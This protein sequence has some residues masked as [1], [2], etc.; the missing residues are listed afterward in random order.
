MI[1]EPVRHYLASHGV[2]FH[3]V[4]HEPRFSAQEAAEAA[5]VSGKHFAKAV[6]LRGTRHNAVRHYLLAVLP[7][8]EKV[9]IDRLSRVLGERYEL[10][11]E[12][13]TATLFPGIEV[14]ALPPL[15]EL[16]GVPVVAD[17]AMRNA[18]WIVF[19]GGRLTDLVE[20][21]WDDYVRVAAPRIIDYARLPF[22]IHS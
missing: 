16:G 20:V 4:S 7:A 2:R 17:A 1:A 19:H 14:G 10:A 15:G 21:S 9:D 12:E 22:P 5:H 6:L 8:H 13:E 11:S 18:R 3:T